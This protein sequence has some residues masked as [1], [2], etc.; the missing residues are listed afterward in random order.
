MGRGHVGARLVAICWMID[1][2]IGH[3]DAESDFRALS[4]LC[5]ELSYEQRQFDEMLKEAAAAYQADRGHSLIKRAFAVS[6]E[7]GKDPG[8][9]GR[10]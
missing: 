2:D 5:S 7:G 9:D 1:R 10:E 6:G 8:I 4:S 3:G